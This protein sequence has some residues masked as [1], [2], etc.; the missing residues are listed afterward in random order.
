MEQ[1][2]PIT[3]LDQNSVAHDPEV[4]LTRAVIHFHKGVTVFKLDTDAEDRDAPIT[5]EDAENWILSIPKIDSAFLE[6]SGKWKWDAQFYRT[7]D[8]HPVT[9]FAGEVVAYDPYTS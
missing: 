8:T 6:E 2:G 7:G 9:L 5:L 4:N 1:I 3:I